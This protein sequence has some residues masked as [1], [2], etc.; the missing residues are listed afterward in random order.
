MRTTGPYTKG[1]SAMLRKYASLLLG[2]TLLILPAIA[3]ADTMSGGPTL[4]EPA[5]ARQ[6]GM[7]EMFGALSGDVNALHYNPAGL[8]DLA[9]PQV[10]SMVTSGL[11]ESRNAYLAAGIPMS[12]LG[13]GALAVSV[14]NWIGAQMDLIELDGSSRSLASQ[15]DLVVSLGYGQ[16]FE[17][18]LCAG[19]AVKMLRST[20][21]EEYDATAFGADLGILQKDLIWPGLQVGLALRDLGTEIKYVDAGDPM[22]TTLLVGAAYGF[23]VS[24]GHGLR[25]GIDVLFPN[26]GDPQQNLGA[27]YT[28]QDQLFA[29]V[30]YRLNNGADQLTAG[31]GVALYGLRLDYAFASAA[32]GQTT[33]RLG[34]GY[35]FNAVVPEP[36]IPKAAAPEGAVPEVAVP[37]VVAPE[38]TAPEVAVPEAAAQ[39]VT[40]P[41]VTVPETLVPEA[42]AP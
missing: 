26:D 9:A 33:H 2:G 36:V 16:R 42:T 39:E 27:E 12:W 34:L 11:F 35:V 14:L 25:L 32:V 23:P 22:P 13:Q 38:V 29:R 20:L 18:G 1:V 21:L 3:Y 15:N 8:A 31:A 7:G 28:W 30:G 4:V 41:E 40:V 10:S 17:H 5:G 19:L 37:Q 24:A 6:A